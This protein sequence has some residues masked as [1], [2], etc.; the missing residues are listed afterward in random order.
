MSVATSG[1]M[2][3]PILKPPLAMNSPGRAG[4]GPS[5]GARDRARGRMPAQRSITGASRNGAG[6]ARAGDDGVELLIGRYRIVP[7]PFRGGADGHGGVGMGHDVQTLRIELRPPAQVALQ[8]GGLP[9]HAG[10]DD[11][12]AREAVQLQET[13]K[14]RGMDDRSHRG[15]TGDH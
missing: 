2:P 1:A 8:H 4:C 5:I 11:P 13:R 15:G 12:V 9:L 14:T 7:F 3:K 6:R 10:A